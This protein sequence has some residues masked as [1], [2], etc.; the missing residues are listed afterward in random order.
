[1]PTFW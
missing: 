1:M